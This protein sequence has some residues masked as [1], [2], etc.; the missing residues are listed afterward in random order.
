MIN[1]SISANSLFTKKEMYL[2]SCKESGKVRYWA[3]QPEK[4]RRKACYNN[5]HLAYGMSF[6]ATNG[7]AVMQPYQGRTDFVAVHYNDRKKV[8]GKGQM[9]QFFTD[10][11]RFRDTAWYDLERFTYR[12][13]HFDFYATPDF[14][15]WKNTPTEYYNIEA[16]FKTRFVGAYWQQCGY[17]VIPTASWGGM[18][19]FAYCFEGLPK[20]SVIA[21]SGMGN[22][23]NADAFDLWSYGLQRLETEIEPILVLIYGEEMEVPGLHTPLK[24]IPDFISK[25]LN[26]L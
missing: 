5:M 9:L 23:K 18:N 10:D 12:V 1:D 15:M 19:S 2:L 22:M 6:T 3:S 20:Y 16:V 13:S 25:R 24:F 17:D 26:K 8:D 11:Y 21:V 7:F 14:S 4:V